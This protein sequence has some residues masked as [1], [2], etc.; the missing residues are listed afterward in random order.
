MFLSFFLGKKKKWL[1][2]KFFSGGKEQL[3]NLLIEDSSKSHFCTLLFMFN[4]SF[5]SSRK[6]IHLLRQ[7]DIKFILLLGILILKQEYR[8]HC[9]AEQSIH[10]SLCASGKQNKILNICILIVTSAGFQCWTI[11]NHYTIL[12]YQW[13]SIKEDEY[14]MFTKDCLWHTVCFCE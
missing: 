14:S 4:L 9:Y 10:S 8:P 1:N 12:K 5:Y 13:E 3:P 7:D 11:N 2:F 6:E